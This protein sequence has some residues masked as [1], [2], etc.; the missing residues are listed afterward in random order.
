MLSSAY[1]HMLALRFRFKLTLYSS[2]GQSSDILEERKLREEGLAPFPP[3]SGKEADGKV[4]MEDPET[5]LGTVPTFVSDD[6]IMLYAWKKDPNRKTELALAAAIRA[7]FLAILGMWH[8][9]S[10]S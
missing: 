4:K 1:P 8:S 7:N 6:G 10:Y 9:T 3:D 5:P 2:R